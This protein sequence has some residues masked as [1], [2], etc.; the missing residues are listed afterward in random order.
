MKIFS[1]EQIRNWDA[2][3]IS[4][5][6]ISSSNL[7][8]RAATACADWIYAH[9]NNDTPVNVVCGNG[10]NGGDGLAL[11]RLL[12]LTGYPVKVILG[13]KTQR[14]A[15][16]QYNLDLLLAQYP[17]CILT[18]D[19]AHACPEHSILID[20]LFG[21]G[22]NKKIEGEEARMILWMNEQGRPIISIDIP[23]GMDGDHLNENEVAIRANHTL[24]FQQYKKSFLW[25]ESDAYCGRIHI[26]DIGLSQEYYHNTNSND[27]LLDPEMMHQLYRP[28]KSFAHKGTYGHALLL[29]GSHGKMGA[30]ILSAKA[31]LRSGAGLCSVMIPESENDIIQSAL[32]EAMSIPYGE[33]ENMPDLTK[34]QSIGL[35]C[36]LGTDIHASRL[37]E[38]LLHNASIPLIL[39]ADALN[40]LSEHPEWLALIPKGSLLTPHPKEFDRLFGPSNNS[41]DRMNLQLQKSKSFGLLILLKGHHTCL[42]TP[43]G[44]CY[45]NSTGNPGMATG[46]SGD[47]LTGIITGLFAQYHDL[48]TAALIG[49]YLHGLAADLAAKEHS[50]ESLI[51]S[52]INDYLGKAFKL[53]FYT[54][55]E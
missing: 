45:F 17:N 39:D 22:L 34:Y 30:A 13:S 4:H 36:G 20:A 6:P 26:L 42:S 3:T 32:P 43:E 50:Q 31:I 35:G 28:R 8:L 12:L 49:M 2:Y 15:D 14:S 25:P 51:A 24:S 1:T 23:S 16:N 29:A 5:E 48:Q 7:M 18:L 54:S 40:I 44:T 33:L 10:N 46:G 38:D 21:T 47:V 11:A 19:K 9:W 55:S 27:Y 41:E 37:L 52:D 53:C